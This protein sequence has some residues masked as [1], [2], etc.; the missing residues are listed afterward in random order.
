[1]G[2][3]IEFYKPT[4][5]SVMLKTAVAV[6][7]PPEDEGPELTPR[8]VVEDL[9]KSIDNCEEIVI[10]GRDKD[11]TTGYV[12]NLEDADAVLAFMAK[13]KFNILK[14]ETAVHDPITP[15]KGYA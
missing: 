8:D 13:I 12:T 3:L 14:I 7:P 15:P 10:L 4:K 5:N 11:G 2:R 6:I 9:L 1:M